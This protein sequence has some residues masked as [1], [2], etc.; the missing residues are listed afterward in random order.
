MR[1]KKEI[2][3]IESLLDYSNRY[4]S[5][6][7]SCATANLFNTA[8]DCHVK[9]V[10]ALYMDTMPATKAIFEGVCRRY[11]N[12]CA[13]QPRIQDANKFLAYPADTIEAFIDSERLRHLQQG[14]QPG[15]NVANA[16]TELDKLSRLQGCPAFTQIEVDL[17]KSA[18]DRARHD[19]K[20]QQLGAEPD[21]ARTKTKRDV[22]TDADSDELALQ[23]MRTEQ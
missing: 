16:Q 18:V 12:W 11:V 8:E 17:M 15:F 14:T 2:S 10:K 19:S 4:S 22:L 1:I 5:P 3:V 6:V 9:L 20:Q 21:L 13:S 7:T 23:G